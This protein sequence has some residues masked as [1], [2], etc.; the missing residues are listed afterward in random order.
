MDMEKQT[1]TFLGIEVMTSIPL[2]TAAWLDARLHMIGLETVSKEQ[3]LDLIGPLEACRVGVAAPRHTN[4]GLVQLSRRGRKPVRAA[5]Q[6]CPMRLSEEALQHSGVRV[7]HTPAREEDCPRWMQH[8]FGLYRELEERG[9]KPYPEGDAALQWLETQP[10]A[11][12]HALLGKPPFSGRTLEGRIQRQL[13]LYDQKLNIP[14]AMTF[15]EEVTRYRLLQGVLPV[16]RVYPQ[17]ALNALA[18]AFIAW[19]AVEH[20]DKVTFLGDPREGRMVLPAWEGFVQV[21]PAAEILQPT[22]FEQGGNP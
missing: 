13:T 18:A 2:F 21:H 7:V 6:G 12:F 3:L 14:D 10:E 9:W 5:R 11:V 15:F 8:G 19:L 22:F 20:P 16:D 4:T 17:A 1:Y